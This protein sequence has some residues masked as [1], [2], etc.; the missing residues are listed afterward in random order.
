MAEPAQGPRR[1]AIF[2]NGGH[3]K[4]VVDTIRQAGELTPALCFGSGEPIMMLPLLPD[5]RMGAVFDEGIQEAFVA[6]GEPRLR[7]R[8]AEAAMKQGFR[9]PSVVSPHAYVAPSAVLGQGVLVCA[10]AVIHPESVVGDLA[11]VNTLSSVDHD[12]RLDRLVHV[13][14]GATICGR[15]HIGERSWIGAGATVI[16]NLRIAADVFVASGAAVTRSIDTA[17]GLF[18]GVPARRRDQQ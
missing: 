4:V 12:C 9:L 5:A 1:I 10:G 3:A 8:L 13:A 2:G 6:V 11:I 15:V 14:P 18:A 16:E 17:G 7:E